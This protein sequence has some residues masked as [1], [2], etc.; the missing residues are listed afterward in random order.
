MPLGVS[1]RRYLVPDIE[2]LACQSIISY[3]MLGSGAQ[4]LG[5]I[6]P[7]MYVPRNG[8]YTSNDY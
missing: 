2:Y 4:L 8:E 6:R 3:S 5:N 7:S 1:S